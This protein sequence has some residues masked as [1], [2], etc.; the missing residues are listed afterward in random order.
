MALT[1]AEVARAWRDV[2]ATPSR[3][4]K[5]D[6]IAGLL[7]A[8]APADG[9]LAAAWLAGE[10]P[11]GRIG[12][13]WATIQKS[14][15]IAAADDASLSVHDVDTTFS[16]IAG[17]AGPGSG[18]RRLELLRSLLE[19][20]TP[21]E[22]EFLQRLLIGE[23][24]QGAL[25]GIMVDALARAAGASSAAVR[26]ALLF[27]GSLPTVARAALDP[28]PQAL[29]RFGLRLF[30]PLQP[31]LAGTAENVSSALGRLAHAGFEYKLDG[32][33]IQVHRQ[34][35]DV[36]IY[37][38]NLN[39]VT[40]SL[41]D[42]VELVRD[43]P[44]R[45]LILDGEAIALRKDGRPLP[46]QV[47]MRRFGRRSD[48]ERLRATLPLRCFFFDVLRADGV[49]LLD[50]PAV[51]RFDALRDLLPEP[52]RIMRMATDDPA[53][54]DKFLTDA[55]Q[56][57]H[58]GVIA[59]ALDAP[60][61]AGA[62][63]SAWLKIKPVH[64]LD[65]VVLAAEWGHGRRRG[66]LSNLHL[67]AR[68]PDGFV[69]LGKTFKG[70]TDRT[71][72]WQTRELLARETRRV[73]HVVHVRPE[74]VVEIAFNDIQKSSRYPGGLALRFARVRAYRPDRTAADADTVETVR[75]IWIA[76]SDGGL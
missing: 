49:T 18:R 29:D 16:T 40:A 36:R 3:A 24:R 51:D 39:D 11:Q 21:D 14:G 66:W 5:T 25:D 26:R 45:E 64:T 60:Y 27:A 41:P 34:G 33:R 31:M 56:A 74:L 48:V 9:A 37:T 44:S 46:F 12:I 72:D 63:G 65:L 42:V 70:L 73:G 19:R 47:T 2:S 7:A 68:G 61:D 76:Q 6:R 17:S 4:A 43:L 20:A 10:L 23:L 28:D 15:D 69:M 52:L 59:K 13:G 58:E 32:A 50:Q 8:S 1:L 62:R 30:T 35:D 57:G 38:R 75:A 55:R 71:L 67:G 53:V 54:A 22:R